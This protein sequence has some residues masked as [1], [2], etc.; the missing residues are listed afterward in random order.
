[1]DVESL[2][3]VSSD[4][5]DISTMDSSDESAEEPIRGA[6][7]AFGARTRNLVQML[8]DREVRLGPA[9]VMYCLDYKIRIEAAMVCHNVM[10]FRV[11]P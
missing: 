10:V 7:P 11:I 5:D 3:G 9:G 8:Y 1:M 4:E 6:T 2:S